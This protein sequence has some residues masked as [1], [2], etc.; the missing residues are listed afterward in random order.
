MRKVAVSLYLIVFG[1]S[2]VF[3]IG[4]ET[5]GKMQAKNRLPTPTVPSVSDPITT[6]NAQQIQLRLEI[7][8]NGTIRALAWSPDGNLLAASIINDETRVGTIQI[9]SVLNARLITTLSTTAMDIEFSPGGTLLAAGNSIW[10]IAT[11]SETTL[12]VPYPCAIYGVSFSPNG[13]LIATSDET[14][15]FIRIWDADT[16]EPLW[17]FDNQNLGMTGSGGDLVYSVD[18]A[19]DGTSIVFGHGA[20]IA[21]GHRI[22]EWYFESE[23]LPSMFH[24]PAETELVDGMVTDVSFSPDGN[25]IASSG[26]DGCVRLWNVET[27]TQIGVLGEEDEPIIVVNF[28]PDGSLLVSGGYSEPLRLWNV[29]TQTLLLTLPIANS[30][31]WDAEFNPAGTQLAAGGSEGI[32]YIWEMP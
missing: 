20:G 16:G 26:W 24:L 1:I 19:P 30:I 10:N 2:L 12:N 11:H 17:S 9:Y 27:A 31:I 21:P 6:K 8:V 18:F 13:D 25:L 22:Y 14:C 7:P 32:I 3:L 5:K 23:S 29:E 4:L 15:M 28:S